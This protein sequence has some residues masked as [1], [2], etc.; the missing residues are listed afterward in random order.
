MGFY[1][2]FRKTGKRD[3]KRQGK[4]AARVDL[5]AI[6]CEVEISFLLKKG[7]DIL[8]KPSTSL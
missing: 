2:G 6:I 5:D 1:C 4:V 7:S 8:I 3:Q